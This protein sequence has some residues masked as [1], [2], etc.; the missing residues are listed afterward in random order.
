MSKAM[1]LHFT[2]YFKATSTVTGSDKETLRRLLK[3]MVACCKGK[4]VVRFENLPTIPFVGYTQIIELIHIIGDGSEP[5]AILE[6]D[7]TKRCNDIASA[8]NLREAAEEA[9]KSNNKK[10]WAKLKADRKKAREDREEA[11]AKREALDQHKVTQVTVNRRVRHGYAQLLPEDYVML[12]IDPR[13]PDT[14]RTR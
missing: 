9:R 12:G 11:K 8:Q 5:L 1:L 13:R 14:N 2:P 10:Y 6:K 3:W 7:L 4:G